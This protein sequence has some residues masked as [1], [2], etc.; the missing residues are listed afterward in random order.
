MSARLPSRLDHDLFPFRT[1]NEPAAFRLPGE[2]SIGLAIT[3]VLQKFH[4]GA[5]PLFPYPGILDRP[6]PDVGNG[7]QRDVGMRDGL[8]RVL[9]VLD[10]HRVP[11][12]FVVEHDALP[13]LSPDALAALRDGRNGVA[14]GGRH[15]ALLHTAALGAE[16]E[17]QVI[18][19]A[20]KAVEDAAQRPVQ[21]WRSP[22]IAQSPSTLR[23]LAEEGF[24]YCGDL[25]NDDRPYEIMTESGSLVSVPMHHFSSDLHALFVGRQ[26]TCEY[27]EGF[28][29]A[30][31][32]LHARNTSRPVVIP[33]V[34]HPWIIGAPHRFRHWSRTL[35]RIAA[36][37]EVSAVTGD[38]LAEA[39]RRGAP[40]GLEQPEP[41][42]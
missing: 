18:R 30:V 31:E 28:E 40:K 24:G 5:K 15:A 33:M 8:H 37:A 13:A 11:V 41:R 2:A 26:N 9:E 10:Q 32:W 38:E 3:V 36:R 21:G 34:I 39:L 17:R 22:G 23:L 7:S 27:L 20:R 6:Y 1:L 4:L 25:N 19:D 14:A 35:A 16:D 12:T 29:K 42:L